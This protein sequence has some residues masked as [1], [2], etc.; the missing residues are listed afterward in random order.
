[1]TIVDKRALYLLVPDQ[2]PP[3]GFFLVIGLI[4]GTTLFLTFCA[5]S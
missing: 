2:R 1:M 5:V 3:L 4:V